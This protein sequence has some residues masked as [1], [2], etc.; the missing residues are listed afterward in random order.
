MLGADL[1]GVPARVAVVAMVRDR[2]REEVEKALAALSEVVVGGVIVVGVCGVG[3]GIH[4]LTVTTVGMLR[5]GGG[6]MGGHALHGFSS[7]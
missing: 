5:T 1:A 7:G 6:S 4:L 3:S 2:T